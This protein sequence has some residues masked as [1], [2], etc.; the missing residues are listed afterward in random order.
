MPAHA[1]TGSDPEPLLNPHHEAA[2]IIDDELA[3]AGALDTNNR[4][5]AQPP[6]GSLLDRVRVDLKIAGA[7]YEYRV[8]ARDEEVR[9]YQLAA[10]SDFEKATMK[11]VPRPIAGPV[12]ASI[13]ALHSL[14][15][16]AGYDAYYLVHAHFDKPY[17]GVL[18][19]S[20]LRSL[21]LEAQRTYG[22]DW[23][24]LASINFVESD[25]GRVLGPSSAGAE[26]PMQFLPGTWANYGQGGN[27]NDPHDAI[28]A[29]ARYLVHYGA[30]GD[31]RKAIFH[32]NLDSDYVDSIVYFAQA[33]HED[34]TWLD[35][36][37]YWG[38]TG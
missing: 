17:G 32:Y 30:P 8:A 15:S 9:I 18:T 36:M 5:T 13:D 22:V 25:F 6:S 2:R 4:L 27:I 11:L 37:Y 16:L 24:Y 35:R 31:M 21:Y 12:Q 28:M 20:Q 38:T 34:P 10:Y 26:G 19:A 23:T 7:A 33:F 14:Y 1:I 3:I 29:A